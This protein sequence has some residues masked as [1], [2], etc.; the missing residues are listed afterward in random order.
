MGHSPQSQD[1]DLRKRIRA[2]GGVEVRA[3]IREEAGERAIVLVGLTRRPD[4]RRGRGRG[5]QWRWTLA[6]LRWV[7]GVGRFKRRFPTRGLTH[8]GYVDCVG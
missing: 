1:C 3:E 8:M 2:H 4:L 6:P 5:T 7:G